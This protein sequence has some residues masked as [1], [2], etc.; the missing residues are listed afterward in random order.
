MELLEAEV[1]H[2]APTCATLHKICQNFVLYPLD[3]EPDPDLLSW[4]P[5]LLGDDWSVPD[6]ELCIWSWSWPVFDDL[7]SWLYQWGHC[8]AHLSSFSAPSLP[9]LM[10][11]PALVAPSRL[12]SSHCVELI[13]RVTVLLSL[14]PGKKQAFFS[15]HPR[16]FCSLFFLITSPAV[17]QNPQERAKTKL[18]L[19]LYLFRWQ[20]SQLPSGTFMCF[21]PISRSPSLGKP[22]LEFQQ[23]LESQL[24]RVHMGVKLHI[25][26]SSK[27]TFSL[28][29]KIG[30]HAGIKWI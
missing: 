9:S 11:Q 6:P 22:D 2:L 5:G 14:F 25:A 3:P 15:L 20:N 13:T 21:V 29:Y 1:I 27:L 26:F 7:P 10:E 4:L 17:P 24:T 28:K 30:I 12:G 23:K 18:W 8:S 19:Q 16:L